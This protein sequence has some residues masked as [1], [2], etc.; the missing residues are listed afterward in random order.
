MS[1]VKGKGKG[2]SGFTGKCNYCLQEGHRQRECKEFDKVMEARRAQGKA[3]KG[4]KGD[5]YKGYGGN[6]GWRNDKGGG[7]GDWR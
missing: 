4:G 7:K 6:G 3:G 5:G 1:L 2:K